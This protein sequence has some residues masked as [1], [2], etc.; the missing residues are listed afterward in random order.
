M[1]QRDLIECTMTRQFM[2]LVLHF[3]GAVLALWH[4]QEDRL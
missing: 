2:L 1:A 4:L 3:S